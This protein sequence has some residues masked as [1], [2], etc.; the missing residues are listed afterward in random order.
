VFEV[1]PPTGKQTQWSERVLGSFGASGDG[2][3]PLGS[4]IA[5]ERGNLYG[6]TDIG[7]VYD[8][9]PGLG[10]G[11]GTVFELSLPRYRQKKKTQ[12]TISE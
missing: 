5:D 4:L 1:N 3:S 10:L 6:T 7:G 9:V 8:G 12:A 2:I 11:A